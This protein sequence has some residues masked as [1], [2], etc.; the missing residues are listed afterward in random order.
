MRLSAIGDVAMAVPVLYAL[1]RA[2]P[3]H[4]FTLLTQPFL[5][6]LLIDPP[7][8]LEAMAIDIRREERHLSGLVR[9]ADR[10]RREHFDA[11]IDLH[12]VLR[13]RLLGW[14]LRLSGVPVRTL[15]KPRRQRRRFV[16]RP[17]S[18]DLT[19]L[20]SMLELQRQTLGLL[21]LELP[22]QL[23]PITID[24][25]RIESLAEEHPELAPLLD[26]PLI[27]IAPFASTEAKTYD[28]SLMEQVVAQLSLRDDCRLLLFG[29]RG[30][31]EKLL[32]LWQERYPH[33]HS[34]A[35][36]L[37]LSQELTL[38]SRLRCMLSMD[39]ANMHFASM[40]GVRVLSL[41]C[42]TH[43]SAGFLGLGQSL[44][45]CLQPNLSCRPCSIFG[46]VKACLCGDFPCRRTFPSHEIIRR[47]EGILSSPH[48]S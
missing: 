9:Y 41:W 5:T 47:I 22:Q 25:R 10:L 44:E 26:K 14:S 12:A 16:A 18:K 24:P 38:I 28:L 23:P 39:S 32:S 31:E 35:G 27:G 48:L 7:S 33:V 45:D 21:G 40:V 4:R 11:V 46:R 36:R 43:P 13:T 3:A 29:G 42:S 15:S 6:A 19:P 17:P 37:E 2:Y 8:N 20:P 34:V 30:R 1:A